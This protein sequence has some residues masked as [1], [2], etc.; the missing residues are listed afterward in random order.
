MFDDDQGGGG[1]GGAVYQEIFIQKIETTRIIGGKNS[2]N[3][4]A[5]KYKI[6]CWRWAWLW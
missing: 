5:L 4:L 6:D 3:D 1:G 2:E